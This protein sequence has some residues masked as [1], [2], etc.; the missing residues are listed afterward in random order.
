MMMSELKG[1]GDELVSMNESGRE[2]YFIHSFTFSLI[3]CK[4][5]IVRNVFVVYITSIFILRFRNT[6]IGPAVPTQPIGIVFPANTQGTKL[7]Q[8]VK[9][10]QYVV[11]T[12]TA[13]NTVLYAVSLKGNIKYTH[14]HFYLTV[15]VV[16][17]IT[18][19]VQDVPY[20]V[21]PNINTLAS[22]HATYDPFVETFDLLQYGSATILGVFLKE[23]YMAIL[24]F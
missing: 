12:R 13:P 3:I 14:P 16:I 9:L 22:R 4:S 24:K 8:T 17:I 15:K 10:V 11:Y 5:V 1:G 2:D 23:L 7:S 18:T 19:V 6:V 21:I 20:G